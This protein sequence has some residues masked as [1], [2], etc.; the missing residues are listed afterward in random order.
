MENAILLFAFNGEC[1]DFDKWLQEKA[2][3]LNADN[4][5]D[6]VEVSKRKFEQI[7]T[8]L[9]ASKSR[10]DEID[11]R[12]DELLKAKSA[13][14]PNVRAR[15]KAIHDRWDTINKLRQAKER[16]LQGASRY[17]ASYKW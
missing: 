7:V 4:R 3:Q 13:P 5:S 2:K 14:A 9:S 17:S 6:P 16:N 10:L 8:D 15:L 11:K 12:A 1:D